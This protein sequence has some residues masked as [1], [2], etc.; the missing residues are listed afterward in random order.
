[1][2]NRIQRVT[3]ALASLGSIQ[4]DHQGVYARKIAT[5][6]AHATLAL[7]EQQQIA[8]LLTLAS[9]AGDSDVH[10]SLADVA[11]E[12][13]DILLD[14]VMISE[15]DEHVILAPWVSSALGAEEHK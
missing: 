8:N 5:V 6:Q 3:N 14:S 7:A 4:I 12:A 1:M 15:D 13:L 9:L 11:Y 10:E 2:S